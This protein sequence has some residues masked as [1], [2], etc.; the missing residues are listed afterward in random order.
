MVRLSP[1]HQVHATCAAASMS[2]RSTSWVCV[3]IFSLPVMRRQG[4]VGPGYDGAGANIGG[5]TRRR[6][7][8]RR[9]DARLP[10]DADVSP[11]PRRTLAQDDVQARRMQDGALSR[12][13]AEASVSRWPGRHARSSSATSV[14][15][16]NSATLACAGERRSAPLVRERTAAVLDCMDTSSQRVAAAFSRMQEQDG[17]RSRAA[18]RS[19]LSDR[20]TVSVGLDG[21]PAFLTRGGAPV[22][23]G[24]VLLG[25]PGEGLDASV[26][27]RHRL[28][29]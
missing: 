26:S 17:L 6:L 10:R 4:D 7:R 15:R 29:G 16:P 20:A 21:V 23:P 5:M 13:L 12:R 9:A 22:I 28:S 19:D 11:G 27:L 2:S 1:R 14:R 24:V 8:R 3:V 25:R 18:R